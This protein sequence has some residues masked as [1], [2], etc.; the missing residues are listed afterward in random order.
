MT[1]LRIF[2]KIFPPF[3]VV[4]LV[5]FEQSEFSMPNLSYFYVFFLMAAPLPPWNRGISPSVDLP[6]LSLHGTA[7][8]VH[9]WTSN[10]SN[11]YSNEAFSISR[12]FFR[13]FY[14]N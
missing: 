7:A 2:C 12:I 1:A 9:P 8:L 4:A 13:V 14:E 11:D 6:L 5:V 3:F 10:A